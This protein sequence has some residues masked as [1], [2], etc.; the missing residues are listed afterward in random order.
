MKNRNF[1][2]KTDINS[3]RLVCVAHEHLGMVGYS[4]DF[5]IGDAFVHIKEHAYFVKVGFFN[6]GYEE[7]AEAATFLELPVIT[8]YTYNEYVAQLEQ[9]AGI[10]HALKGSITEHQ[11]GVLHDSL[12]ELERHVTEGQ[13]VDSDVDYDQVVEAII[14]I[15]RLAVVDPNDLKVGRGFID[16][17]STYNPAVHWALK[18]ILSTRH[19]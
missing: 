7:Y 10:A 18:V 5:R 17:P 13:F 2:T 14:A 6:M 12:T 11:M 8:N 9:E 19:Y 16:N 1:I 15:K 3:N 4:A